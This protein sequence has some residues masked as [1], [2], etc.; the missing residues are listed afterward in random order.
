MIDATI[1]RVL[2]GHQPTQVKHHLV[3]EIRC[4][5]TTLR[6]IGVQLCEIVMLLFIG[7]KHQS[8][9]EC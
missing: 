3:Q 7:S 1:V 6:N 2:H 4:C 9:A 8:D 5:V